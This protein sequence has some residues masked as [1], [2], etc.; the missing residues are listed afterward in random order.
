MNR[1]KKI[2]C[3][4][5]QK[6][7]HLVIPILPYRQP[8]RLESLADIP[9]VLKE[10]GIDRILIVTDQGIRSHGLFEPHEQ[11]LQENNIFYEIY[12]KTVAN[13]TTDNEEK[14]GTDG[15]YLKGYEK[16][17]ALYCG[18]PFSGRTVQ[19]STRPC[20]CSSASLRAKAL[21]KLKGTIRSHEQD[22]QE[23]LCADLGKGRFES[24][25]ACGL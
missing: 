3:R 10:K 2:Y 13:P 22:I 6:A 21:A 14:P 12:D 17:A 20:Q 7:F 1:I 18:G 19:C 23:A 8:K 15:R 4:V 25:T 24:L 11:A 16:T 5:F 9:S